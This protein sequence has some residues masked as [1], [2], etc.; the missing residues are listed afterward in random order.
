[1]LARPTPFLFLLLFLITLVPCLSAQDGTWVMD[2]AH[3][4]TK[5]LESLFLKQLNLLRKEHKLHPLRSDTVLIKAATDQASYMRSHKA[6]GHTQI[7][8]DKQTPSERELFYKGAHEGVGE[9]VLY[10]PLFTSLKRK[11]G[12]VVTVRT[13]QEAADEMFDSWFNSPPHF[14]NMITPYYEWEGMGF[15][16]DAREKKLYAAQ[17]FGGPVYIPVP[18][19]LIKDKAWGVGESQDLYC[20]CIKDYNFFGAILANYLSVQGDSVF[21]YYQD[22]NLVKKV[23]T[24]NFDGIAVDVVY[25]EQFP[26]GGKNNLHPSPVFDGMMLEPVFYPDL[27]KHNQYKKTGELYTFVAKLPA[28]LKGRNY[29]LN[30][31]LLKTRHSCGYSYPVHLDDENL[32]ALPISV[33]WNTTTGTVKADSFNLLL[34]KNIEFARGITELTQ[35]EK[36]LLESTLGDYK[37]Y[38]RSIEIKTFSSIE[39][40]TENN[41]H[42]QTLRAETIRNTLNRFTNT[43]VDW[44]VESKENWEEFYHQIDHTTFAYLKTWDKNKI[45]E[46]MNDKLFLDSMEI[47]LRKQRTAIVRLHLSGSYSSS[48]SAGVSKIAFQKAVHEGDSAQAWIIQSRMIEYYDQHRMALDDIIDNAVPVTR[49]FLPVLSNIIA[50]KACDEHFLYDYDFRKLIQSAIHAG[51]D[52]TPLKLSYCVYAIKYLGAFN[53]TL[54]ENGQIEKYLGDCERDTKR[55]FKLD[56]Y[57]LDYYIVSAYYYYTHHHFDKLDHCLE[58]IRK[59]YPKS[60][61]TEND[62]LKLAKLFNL[63]FK[64]HWSYEILY[65]FVKKGTQNEDLLFVFLKVASLYQGDMNDEDYIKYIKQGRAMNAKRFCDWINKESWQ[66]LRRDFIK[67]LYCETC[68]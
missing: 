46:R 51:A 38:I 53:D 30:T 29:Q 26:C 27:M 11:S 34:N 28:S 48:P 62:A 15:R 55:N 13:Y 40:S 45:K 43:Q 6:I 20:S 66:L 18:G 68:K 61:I 23:L 59:Y 57:Y 49:P 44:K 4:D 58:G 35:R 1:M 50:A 64:I 10:I 54:S 65:P 24:G 17:V 25:R 16:Y 42:L 32:Q 56:R 22:L 21:L 8:K 14:Q 33:Y 67:G 31:I 41:I 36:D 9:N 39:G 5:L 52:Y 19:L 63:Y 47:F 60:E 12:K 7:T 37:A 3:P 2:T